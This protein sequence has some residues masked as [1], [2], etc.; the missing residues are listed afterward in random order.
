MTSD[1]FYK[2]ERIVKSFFTRLLAE[3]TLNRQAQGETGA[4]S[5]VHEGQD[6]LSPESTL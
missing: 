5:R 4:Q 2:K 3:P 1:E 6:H